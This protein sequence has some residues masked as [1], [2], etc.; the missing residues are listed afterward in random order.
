MLLADI[1]SLVPRHIVNTFFDFKEQDRTLNKLL[2]EIDTSANKMLERDVLVP[3]SSNNTNNT[4]RYYSNNTNN[5][6]RFSTNNRSSFN[7][8]PSFTYQG[9]A[10][11]NENCLFCNKNHNSFNCRVGTVQDRLAVA[12]NNSLC[13]NC[14]KPGHFSN[15]CRK[16]NNCSCGRSNKH[17]LPLCLADAFTR[18][19]NPRGNFQQRNRNNNSFQNSRNSFQNSNSGETNS[20]RN[21]NTNSRPAFNNSGNT[22]HSMNSMAVNSDP[23]V[24][25]SSIANT[26]CFMEIGRGFVKCNNSN[27]Y[28]PLRF[29]FDTASNGSY[30]K[31]LSF[32]N[33]EYSKLGERKLEIDTFSAGAVRCES[34]DI[35]QFSVFDFENC[36][37][38][39]EMCI[40]LMDVLCNGVPT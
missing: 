2:N 25:M 30:G 13:N 6:S 8:R 18:T 33:V 12:R 24:S 14:L 9:Q 34:C 32:S 23:N 16:N 37:E 28:V 17:C 39:T 10:S 29:L 27:D 20:G 22:Q 3:K 26:E 1:L 36:F 11:N 5:N 7:N 4:G 31:R 19:D 35:I 15:D 38:P 21:S 40:S